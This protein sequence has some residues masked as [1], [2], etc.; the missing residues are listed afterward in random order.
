MKIFVVV[1]YKDIEVLNTE[2]DTDYVTET[3]II[4]ADGTKQE[5]NFEASYPDEDEDY[6]IAISNLIT[7]LC[8]AI[9]MAITAYIDAT[10]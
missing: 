3:E 10:K 8:I 1:R 7:W 2:G 6:D 5:A 9:T 4:E